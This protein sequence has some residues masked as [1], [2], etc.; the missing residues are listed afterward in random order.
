MLNTQGPVAGLYNAY[1]GGGGGWGA[2]GGRG[3]QALGTTLNDPANAASGGSANQAGQAALQTNIPTNLT[4][5]GGFGGN[6]V[7]LNGNSV[8]WQAGNTDRVWGS[9]S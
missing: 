8:T 6:A 3:G 4:G 9:I 5:A 7:T 2:A 1:G